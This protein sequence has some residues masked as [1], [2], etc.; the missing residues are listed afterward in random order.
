MIVYQTYM[1]MVLVSLSSVNDSD[2]KL[3]KHHYTPSSTVCQQST[4]ENTLEYN[5]ITT[6]KFIE[7]MILK[8]QDII[9]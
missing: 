7:S 5:Y 2:F 9:P 6:E 3:N 8:N 1:L 4:Q